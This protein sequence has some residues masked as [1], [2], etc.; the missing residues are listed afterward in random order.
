MSFRNTIRLFSYAVSIV[1]VL[2]AYAIIGNNQSAAYKTKLEAVYQQSLMELS[3]CLDSIETNLTKSGYAATPTMMA[4]LSED[5]SS[6]CSL[7]KNELSHLPIEQMNLSGTYKFLSQAA[8]Y[9]EYLSEKTRTGTEISN[10]EYE[11]MQKLL[12][13]AKS[14]SK[15]I[16]EMV[17]RCT[18]GGDITG[19]EVKSSHSEANV[20]SLS[21]DFTQA[22]EAFSDYPTL[23]YDGPFAD[24]VL[25]REPAVTKDAPAKTR[26]ECLKIAAKALYVN[27]DKLTYSGD[28]NGAIPCYSYT[29][30]GYTVAVSKG[31]GYVAYILGSGKVSSQSITQENA[32][33]VAKAY[34]KK[35]GYQDMV[36]TY[37]AVENNVCVINFAYSKNNVIYYSDLI[38]VGVSLA[39]GKIYSLEADGFL[40]NHRERSDF[41]MKIA[42][43]DLKSK[44]S[45][46][47][48]VISSRHCVIPKKNGKEAPCVEYHC[49]NKKT[50]DEVLIYINTHT[51][52]EENILMLLYSD[53]GTLTK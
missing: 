10:E 32:V 7:A 35:L 38:K 3:E 47:V 31:G 9:S 17:T 26:D 22:E 20:A 8:D 27:V 48:E 50:G 53:N 41:S 19:N 18:N 49:R 14:Y 30:D 24:A 23:I 37:Y 25:N 29:M 15:S 43:K 13:Y 1:A 6:E 42:E 46:Y 16:K 44:I 34:L 28:S 5:L 45:K 4:T 33:N 2:A 36:Q 40:T 12:E 51:G 39:D 11:N 52:E 21:L